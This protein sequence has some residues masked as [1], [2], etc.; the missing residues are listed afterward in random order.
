LSNGE[1]RRRVG[2]TGAASF[3]GDLG[4]PIREDLD[5]SPNVL[6]ALLSLD[7]ELARTARASNLTAYES[8]E[9]GVEALKS[10]LS[11][12]LRLTLEREEGVAKTAL[13]RNLQDAQKFT[14]ASIRPNEFDEMIEANDNIEKLQTFEIEEIEATIVEPREQ[15]PGTNFFASFSIRGQLGYQFLFL[16]RF[17]ISRNRRVWIELDAQILC[18]DEQTP[19]IKFLGARASRIHRQIEHLHRENKADF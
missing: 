1:R 6:A 18:E 10:D 19:S 13:Y 14:I 12:H 7:K 17:P 5:R 4:I 11:Q 2:C 9:A 8:L 3:N 16:G 15:E